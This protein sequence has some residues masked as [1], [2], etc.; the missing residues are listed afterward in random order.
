M[1]QQKIGVL[2]GGQLG[3]M[4]CQEASKLGIRLNIL[5]KDDTFP[6]AGVCPDI[7]YGNFKDYDDVL[8]FGR[9]MDV[10]TVEI[11]AVNTEALHQLKKEGKAV[12]PQPELLDLIKDKGDQ[13]S[14][15]AEHEVPTAP[16]ELFANAQEVKAAVEEGRWTIPFV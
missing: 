1:I 15:Y 8:A 10:I 2:G 13:K 9:G 7:T 11:E 14:W 16:F 5:E 3:K 4:L 6:S 12:Y